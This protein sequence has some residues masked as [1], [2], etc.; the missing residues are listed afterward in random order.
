M[1]KIFLTGASSGIGW[2]IAERLWAEGHE[3]WGT[4]RDAER[5]PVFARLHAVALD[6]ADAG[7][8][9]PSFEAALADAGYFDVVI[10]NAGSGHFDPAASVSTEMVA[11]QFQVLALAQI[12]L[13]QLGLAAMQQSGGGMIINISSMAARLPVPYMS[14]YNAAKAA[15][16]SFTMT[17]QLELAGS[18]IHVIDIQPADIR[19]SFNDAVVKA[20]PIDPALAQVWAQVDRNMNEAPPPDL[21]AR[22]VSRLIEEAN[23]PPRITI[24]G[25]FQ[26]TVAPLIF[27]LLPQR[28]RLWGLKK[29]YRL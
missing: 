24:G 2:A 17:L 9:R 15:M 23:P 3:V 25:F 1:K 7:A 5:V 4:A 10:N 29:Y 27:K 14:A 20:K 28:L 13:C 18:N 21:V 11:Q 16:A 22:R 19:T 8:V 26:A 12:Q 6:L